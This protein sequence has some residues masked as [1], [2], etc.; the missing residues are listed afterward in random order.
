MVT[1]TDQPLQ[2][3]YRGGPDRVVITP[4]DEDRFVL[5]RE[6]AI[7]ACQ[8]Y[9]EKQR[10]ASQFHLLLKTLARWLSEHEDQ[11]KQAFLTERDKGLLFLVVQREP[12][13]D[14][15]LENDLTELDLQIAQD[16]DLRLIPLSVLAVPDAGQEVPLTFLSP[17]L[18][19]QFIRGQ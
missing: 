13:Y 16:T 10:F 17:Q 3:T 7:R 5:S 2:L 11:V 18:R 14:E 8:A 1:H 9:A 15:Q 19:I 6:E 12:R 4:A